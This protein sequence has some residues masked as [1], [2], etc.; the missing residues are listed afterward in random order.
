MRMKGNFV[1]PE[2][3]E[4]KEGHVCTCLCFSYEFKTNRLIGFIRKQNGR[5]RCANDPNFYYNIYAYREI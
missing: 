5:Y 3:I 1:D 4:P 2:I